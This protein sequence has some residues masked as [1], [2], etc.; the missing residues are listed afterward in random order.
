MYTATG[1]AYCQESGHHQGR[2]APAGADR[3]THTCHLEG[4]GAPLAS[5]SQAA[6]WCEVAGPVQANQAQL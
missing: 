4:D 5:A 1:Q 6:A 2:R 3:V